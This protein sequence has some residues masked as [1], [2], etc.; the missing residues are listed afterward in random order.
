MHVGID[1]TGLPEASVLHPIVPLL[2][3]VNPEEHVKLHAPFSARVPRVPQLSFSTP[4]W[5]ATMPL[6]GLGVNDILGPLSLSLVQC[7][8]C[9]TLV[10]AKVSAQL[11]TRHAGVQG[12]VATGLALKMRSAVAIVGVGA[13]EA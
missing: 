9:T 10:V 12:A 2:D 8:I 11:R 5:G 7:T 4:F 1:A 6:H 3:A 13:A